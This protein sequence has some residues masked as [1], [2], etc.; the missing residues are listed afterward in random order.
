MT[1]TTA[2]TLQARA[3][4]T[5][6]AADHRFPDTAPDILARLYVPG[7]PDV[8]AD[9]HTEISANAEK[10]YRGPRLSSLLLEGR[11]PRTVTDPLDADLRWRALIWSLLITGQRSAYHANDDRLLKSDHLY[12]A[13]ADHLITTGEP[14]DR[15]QVELLLDATLLGLIPLYDCLQIC[16]GAADTALEPHRERIRALRTLIYN[17]FARPVYRANPVIGA[18]Q[19][20]ALHLLLRLGDPRPMD[21]LF[22]PGDVFGDVLREHHPAL[23]A[24]PGLADLFV[25]LLTPTGTRPTKAWRRRTTLFLNA[26]DDPAST[27]RAVLALVPALPAAPAEKGETHSPYLRPHVH[28]ILTGMVW[29]ADLLPREQTPWVVQVLEP[30]A[31]FAGTGLGGSKQLRAERMA[32]AAV[33]ILG[34]RGTAQDRDALVRIRAEVTK[35]TLL[36]TIDSA[37]ATSPATTRGGRR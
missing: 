26:L 12:A 29:C 34:G 16:E 11:G 28:D 8:V 30:L 3:W 21:E 1:P 31:V 13:V 22:V 33:R 2:P 27:V 15:T 24:T 7:L 35:K 17:R 23:H 37:L 5:R 19:I 36:K 6:I 20:R 9:L 14:W 10:A 18:L 25:H 32:T 4:A